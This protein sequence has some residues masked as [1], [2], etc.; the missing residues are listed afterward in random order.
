MKKVLITGLM[1]LPLLAFG[2]TVTVKD[3]VYTTYPFSDPDPVPHDSHIYPYYKFEKFSHQSIQQTWKTVILE[4]DYLRVRILPDVGGKIWSIYD[5]KQG[6][7]LFYDN[8]AIKF[9]DISLRGPWTS[10]GIEFNFGV[11]GHAPSCSFPV[12]YCTATKEDGSVSCWIGVLDLLTRTR[13]TV[14]INLPKD[15][16]WV[17]TKTFW[18]N[19][20]GDFQPYY[21]WI[22]TGVKATPDTRILYPAAYAIGHDGKTFSFPIEEGTGRDL[23]WLNQQNY[24]MDKSYHAGGSGK[25]WF[26]SWWADEDF[27]MMHYAL[28]DDKVGRKYFS[29]AQS[30]AGEIWREL[31]TDNKPQ[32]IELQS[33]RLFNQNLI[34]SYK[35]PY[36]QFLFTPYGTD[37]YKEYWFPFAGIGAAQEA[38]LRAVSSV[39]ASGN[40][41]RVSI[42]PL[43]NLSGRL[44]LC[45]AE[46]VLAAE[47]VSLQTAVAWS[48]NFPDAAQV[49]KVTLDGQE[50]WNKDE[51]KLTRPDVINEQFD[52]NSLPGNVTIAQYYIGMRYY[53]KAAWHV[54]KALDMDPAN[55]AALDLSAMIALH[56]ADWQKAFDDASKALAVDT[57]DP[58]ANYLRGQAAVQL[59]RWNDAFDSFEIAAITP[60]LRGAAS[61][62]LSALY[63]MRGEKELAA[64]Y[65]DKA[66]VC[67]SNNITA[68][69]LNYLATSDEAW[70]KKI[71][72]LD[73]LNHYPAFIRYAEGRMDASS[74]AARIQQE[75]NWQEYLEAAVFFNAIAESRMAEKI[76][77]ACPEQNILTAIWSAWLNKDEAAL[78]AALG[79]PMDQVFAFRTESIEP[80]AWAL[81]KTSDWKAAYLLSALY[82]HLGR[83]DEAQ[84]LVRDLKDI[85]YAPFY[86]YRASLAYN[87]ADLLQAVKLDPIAWRYVRSIA[88]GRMNEGRHKDAAAILA[89]YYAKHKDNFYIG[90]V[91]AKALIAC[92]EWKKAEKV[93]TDIRILPYE[94]QAASHVMYRD[95]KLHLAAEAVDKGNYKLALQKVAESRLWPHNLGV[96]KPYD[97]LIDNK[98]E[99]WIEA[100]VLA[101]SGKQAEAQ[102]LL[103]KLPADGA[104]KDNYDAA[105]VKKGGK[106]AKISPMLG[107]MDANF[108]KRLF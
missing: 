9:R 78:K 43:K 82:N 35:T 27:G 63:W 20:S 3:T 44:E 19:A 84:A 100:V 14:E 108:D 90:E 96:G 26:A 80:L 56:A 98:A 18:H 22:N 13:W 8:D 54:K 59:G 2:Q 25:G 60:E 99:D 67:N 94:G 70:L 10:G 37:D 107:N 1:L 46:G 31:L 73:P 101:R 92:Q 29:W 30:D 47:N 15:K 74:L 95:I 50:V 34:D 64:L 65:A 57:Y 58:Q 32:Y 33:G 39:E 36:K 62:R 16:T 68:C 5:K 23:S 61:T 55:V 79:Q 49:E 72:S 102:A 75:L 12:D 71:E 4:N 17:T 6:K 91:Y 106:Y 86:A 76:L 93:M 81:E 53:D 83:K 88:F 66:L 77:A 69:V 52:E 105:L 38:N 40:D 97:D 103:Q 21:T 89:S 45:G 42:Y 24:G 48:K 41:A 28:R 104:W 11:I 85:P 87:E 7:E 51:K